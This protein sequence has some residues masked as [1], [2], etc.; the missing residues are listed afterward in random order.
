MSNEDGRGDTRRPLAANAAAAVVALGLAS[1]LAVPAPARAYLMDANDARTLDP[2]TL[3]LELQPIGYFQVLGEEEEHHL[4]AP[5]LML[6]LGLA[7]R[8]DLIFLSRGFATLDDV[9]PSARYRTWES[10]I[11]L[12]WLLVDGRYSTEGAEGPSLVL[13]TGLMLPNV[14]A[15]ERPG[16]QLGMLLGQQ[17]DAGT[18][19]ANVY[20]TYTSWDSFAL[21]VAVAMEGPPEW[22]LRPLVEVWY[23]HDTYY[24]D[25]LSGLVGFYAD[26]MDALTLEIG[27]RVGAWAEYAE[28]EIRVSMWME[29]PRAWGEDEPEEGEA[30]ARPNAPARGTT[31]DERIGR[32]SARHVRP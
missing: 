5:S 11:A 12:R 6:Y 13:Q 10:T 7:E 32:S 3:E 14:G 1:V 2:G 30:S 25:L 16:A 24:G 26:A 18:L 17:W 23:D 20:A 9:P 4:V 22:P 29:L 28:L 31:R 19:H 8:V 21:F 27:A 15:Q